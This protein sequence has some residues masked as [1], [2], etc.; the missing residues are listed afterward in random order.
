MS[1]EREEITRIN[2]GSSLDKICNIDPRGY[3]VCNI[4]Y[5]GARKEMGYPLTMNAALKMVE[6]IKE[7]SKVY[8]ITGFV[9][10]NQ[11]KAEMDGIVSSM[12]LA[13]AIVKAFNAKPVIVC[14]SDNLLAVRNLAAVVGLNLFEDLDLLEE[15]DVSMSVIQF[16]KDVGEATFLTEKL[17]VKHLPDMVISIEAPGAN[18]I[19]RYHNAIGIDVTD[20]EAKADILFEK[21]VEAGVPNIA[22]G[23]LGNEIGM[24]RIKEFIK[25]F[26]PYAAAGD[27]S[28]G[29]GIVAKS[30]SDNIITATVSDWGCAGMIAALSYLLGDLDI[31]QDEN[32][33]RE[34]IIT[35]SRSGM[36]DMTGWMIPAIDGVDCEVNVHI[37]SL[38]RDIVR[39][40]LK[41]RGTGENWYEGVDRLGFFKRKKAI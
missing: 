21:L 9:L 32:L 29:G 27:C 38:M 2:L 7:G 41:Y 23:D 1:M 16:P 11:K 25:E 8:I 15:Y 35:A 31:L 18:D 22:I 3:G 17:I 14:P 10:P 36:I 20:M 26:I 30:S 40:T 12:L 33:A 39:T 5:E 19:G 6:S 4:L 24:G 37:L 28:C 13:R 34:A